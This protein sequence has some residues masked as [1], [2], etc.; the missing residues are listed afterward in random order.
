MPLLPASPPR[1]EVYACVT[2]W[3]GVCLKSSILCACG[4]ARRGLGLLQSA[5]ILLMTSEDPSNRPSAQ[6]LLEGDLS[7]FLAGLDSSTSESSVESLLQTPAPATLLEA[8]AL[9]A[10]LKDAL[11]ARTGAVGMEPRLL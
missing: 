8:H 5:R 10:R 11:R 1:C 3:N 4:C 6:E 2:A 9:I 7:L